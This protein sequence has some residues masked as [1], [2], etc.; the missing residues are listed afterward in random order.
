ME[1]DTATHRRHRPGPGALPAGAAPGHPRTASEVA[2]LQRSRSV[3]S[4][5]QKGDPPSCLR[6]PRKE[7]ESE[8][9]GKDR[10]SDAE[11][12]GCQGNV[13]EGA[14]EKEEGGLGRADPAAGRTEPEPEKG[15]SEA[16]TTGEPRGERCHRGEAEE[17]ESV[18]LNDLEKEKP[19][20][21][22]EIDLRDHTEEVAT[23]AAMEEKRS[24]M[25]TGDASEDETRTSWVCCIPYTAKRRPK[26]SA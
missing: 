20:V 17:Q 11:D 15:G 13:E 6:K 9:P 18:G 1:K 7:P 23:C 21:F 4:L 10:R 14:A 16:S 3:G 19:S 2:E 24:W 5:H 12:A 22:V 26:D 8:D 25:D